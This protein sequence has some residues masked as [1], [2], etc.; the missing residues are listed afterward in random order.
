L[1]YKLV[2][3]EDGKR[4]SATLPLAHPLCV[5]YDTKEY[6]GKN[7]FIY[8][9]DDAGDLFKRGWDLVK[10]FYNRLPKRGMFELWNCEALDIVR[11][12]WIPM[13]DY[14][15]HDPYKIKMIQD[16]MTNGYSV[17]SHHLAE[18]EPETRIARGG[19]R[20]TRIIA[21]GNVRYS[22]FKKAA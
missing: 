8:E 15:D 6:C 17:D 20:L 9:S 13:I 16:Y 14:Q 18:I 11:I 7:C 19:V 4:T 5:A 21:A 22:P 10:A 12:N 3:R 2:V 1:Y